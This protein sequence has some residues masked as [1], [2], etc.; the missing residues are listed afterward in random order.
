MSTKALIPPCGVL[1][2]LKD[3][4]SRRY[5]IE[6]SYIGLSNGAVVDPPHRLDCLQLR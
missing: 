2:Y 4:P 1:V 5:Q 3:H 6:S